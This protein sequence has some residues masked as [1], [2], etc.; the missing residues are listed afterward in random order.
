MKYNTSYGQ[1]SLQYRCTDS[2]IWKNFPH[3]LHNSQTIAAFKRQLKSHLLAS[4]DSE[5]A[6]SL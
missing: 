3:E 6:V 2:D 1:R 5:G 4:Q